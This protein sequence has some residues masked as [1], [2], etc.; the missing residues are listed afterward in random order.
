L[1]ETK[2]LFP[3]T[4][5]DESLKDVR[6]IQSHPDYDGD[7][8]HHHVQAIDAW[9]FHQIGRLTPHVHGPMIT[10]T[11]SFLP[12]PKLDWGMDRVLTDYMLMTIAELLP[13]HVDTH[14]PR[15]DVC[16]HLNMT[17]SPALDLLLEE[18]MAEPTRGN[19]QY[20]LDGEKCARLARKL[21]IYLLP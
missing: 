14:Y 9:I 5:L 20:Q 3:P 7:L 16:F 21:W 8:F 6:R 1:D 11:I 4:P 13:S 2:G 17:G 12:F 10:T 19:H 15:T 18:F